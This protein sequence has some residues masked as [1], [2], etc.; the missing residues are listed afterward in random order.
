MPPFEM[1][2]HVVVHVHNY[3]KFVSAWCYQRPPA[4]TDRTTLTLGSWIWI[5]ECK[6]QVWRGREARRADV[7][8][9]IAIW[10]IVLSPSFPCGPA[11][12]N[13]ILIDMFWASELIASQPSLSIFVFLEIKDQ[14]PTKIY[15][16]SLHD[17]LPISQKRS[18]ADIHFVE[19]TT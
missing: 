15:T 3:L 13:I 17:A 2:M 9:V 18:H 7:C 14:T 4:P 5:A 1:L 11:P 6:K 16:L 12:P 19:R 8:W 10:M